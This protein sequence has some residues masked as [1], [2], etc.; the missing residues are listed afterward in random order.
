V[1]GSRVQSIVDSS[2]AR[3]RTEA[4]RGWALYPPVK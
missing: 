4:M 2:R 3:L 1:M